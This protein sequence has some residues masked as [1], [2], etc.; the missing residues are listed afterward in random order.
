MVHHPLDLKTHIVSL[1]YVYVDK[2]I[3]VLFG[4]GAHYAPEIS[5]STKFSFF[6]LVVWIAALEREYF[7]H[8]NHRCPQFYPVRTA[9]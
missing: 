2:R 9:T 8:D 6:P 7:N 5:D 4:R 3:V 1:R